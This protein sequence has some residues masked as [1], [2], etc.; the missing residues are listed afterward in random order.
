MATLRSEARTLAVFVDFENLA[1]AFTDDRRVAFDIQRV[2]DRL[3]EKGNVVVRKAYA[4][5]SR[6]RHYT[7]SLHEAGFELQ[8]IPKRSMTGKNS[9]D[10]R[11]VVDALD[12]SYSK[13]HI[14]TFVIVSGDSDFSP[15]VAKLRENGKTVLGLGMR[16]STSRLL[17]DHCDEFLFYDDLEGEEH[18][19][20]EAAEVKGGIP[21]EKREAWLLLFETIR[22]L[23][24]EGETA[25]SSR[26]K[27]TMKR[28]RPSFSESAYGY[29]S[30]TEL[31]EDVQ[32]AGHIEL[33]VDER[34]G[35]YKVTKMKSR[36]KSG[37]RRRSSGGNASRRSSS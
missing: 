23:Q 19:E 1:L 2:L 20:E 10:I 29:R 31:L 27:D 37:R 36:A 9:A 34:S 32:K 12:L 8:E 21:A 15:V 18:I 14:D 17:A 24:R 13:D 25:H 5:W 11:L 30:F 7:K 35:T 22:A 3:L 33:E 26:L 6:F 4:D 28:K 16:Q